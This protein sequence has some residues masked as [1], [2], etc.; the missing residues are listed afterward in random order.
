MSVCANVEAMDGV[1]IPNCPASF[2]IDPWIERLRG[3]SP[4]REHAI[5]ELRALLLR[6]LS[7]C[8][9]HRY[10]GAIHIDDVVQVAIIR[11]LNTMESFEGRSKF[12]TWALSI[13]VRVGI[14]ELRRMHYRDVSLDRND[15]VLAVDFGRIESQVESAEVSVRQR[16]ILQLL[17]QLIRESLTERQRDAICGTLLGLPIEEIAI[18]LE[19]NR[20]AVY[21]LVQDARLRLRQGFELNGLDAEEI[22][23]VF[24][25][26]VF[27]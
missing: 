2:I 27:E 14:S 17:E 15:G 12:T 26:G 7:K 18:R 13:A 11:I 22:A 5:G 21:K 6:G 1:S 3:D 24:N 10:G 16:Q 9:S 23:S 19:S 25:K 20:N 8:L 4:E